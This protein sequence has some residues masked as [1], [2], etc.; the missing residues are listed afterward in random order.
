[1]RLATWNCH[2]GS[3]AKWAAL[4]AAGATIAVIAE[5]TT[6]NPVPDGTLL[7]LPLHWVAG[8]NPKKALV[9][10]SREPLHPLPPRPGQG[11]FTVAARTDQQLSILGVWSCPEGSGGR[12]YEDEVIA[13]LTAWSDE[14]AAGDMVV[15]GDFNVGYATGRTT[16]NPWVH[17][18]HTL[19]TELGLVSAYHTFYNQALGE[20]NRPTH[21]NTYKRDRGWHID[22]VLLHRSRISSLHSVTVGSYDDW[23]AAGVTARSDHVPVIV[24]FGY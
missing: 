14:L 3:L 10:A 13:T 22:W 20:T 9:I 23:T 18:A 16:P 19:W 17:R 1:V 12:A 11:R 24:D 8:G 5:T 4:E 15:A 2:S 6:A 7:D 21:F